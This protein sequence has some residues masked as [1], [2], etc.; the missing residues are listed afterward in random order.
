VLHAVSDALLGASGLGDIGDL[1]PPQAKA[2]CG[3][4]SRKITETVLAR[5]GEK[6]FRIVNIDITVIAQKPR[7]VPHKKRMTASLRKIYG[8]DE[9]NLK[10]K[11]KEGG[12]FLGG[13]NTISCVAAALL[14]R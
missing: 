13:V 10:I 2:S 9:V 7:L 12:S 14:A 8:V 4:S 3:I 1:F 5:I 6:K 11:S